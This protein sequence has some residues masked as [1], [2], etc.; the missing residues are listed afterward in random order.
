MRK[1]EQTKKNE[2]IKMD[3]IKKNNKLKNMKDQENA[4][5]RK[6]KKWVKMEKTKKM[7]TGK[8]E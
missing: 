7:I 6:S 2:K 4:T 5:M 3:K 8:Y 1:K